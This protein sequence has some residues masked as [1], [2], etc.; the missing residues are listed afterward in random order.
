MKR[1][2]T[3]YVQDFKEKSNGKVMQEVKYAGDYYEYSLTVTE[4][5]KMRKVILIALVMSTV[6]YLPAGFLNNSGSFCF[7]VLLPYI[8]IILPLTYLLRAYIR[9]PREL[10]KME[11]AI[12][13]KS[14]N[15][16]K[17][18][19]VGIIATS[20]TTVIGDFI[21]IIRNFAEIAIIK[22]VVFCATITVM[23]IIAILLLRYHNRIVCNKL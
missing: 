12:Y 23:G 22:E 11:F 14:Y 1:Y 3:D 2:I 19:L 4:Y 15:R 9:I 21:F 16:V 7:Y 5:N 10:Q 6:S 13:D 17:F 8:T 20:L 18:S